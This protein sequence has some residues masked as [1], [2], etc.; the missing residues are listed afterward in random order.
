M[1]AK[2]LLLLAASL[3]TPLA[4]SAQS[5]VVSPPDGLMVVNGSLYKVTNGFAVIVTGNGVVRGVD[6][7]PVVIPSGA[8]YTTDGRLIAI[9]PGI[10]GLPAGVKY[11]G[12]QAARGPFVVPAKGTPMV[13]GHGPTIVPA[14]GS[15]RGR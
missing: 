7:N 5:A 11:R 2:V 12:G 6:G 10:S 14:N 13:P 1:N 3:A 9:P 15:G 8:M 4:A